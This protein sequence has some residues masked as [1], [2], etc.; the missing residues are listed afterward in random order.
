MGMMLSSQQER[1]FKKTKDSLPSQ[2]M[3]ERAEIEPVS[4]HWK[5]ATHF[6][7]SRTIPLRLKF[8]THSDSRGT[9]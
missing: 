4:R 6:F 1:I 7:N 2:K 8:K 9:P 5:I 3:L